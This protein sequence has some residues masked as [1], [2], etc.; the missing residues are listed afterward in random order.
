M[1]IFG[2][3]I[4]HFMQSAPELAIPLWQVLL[5]V[6]LISL[7]ALYERYRIILILSYVF[8]AYW[9][10]IENGALLA[11]NYIWVVTGFIFLVFGLVA[12]IITV[13]YMMTGRDS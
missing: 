9:V 13:Y 3:Y 6:L 2:P 1:P 4:E 11:L 12:V 8:M 5:F 7:A 10:F